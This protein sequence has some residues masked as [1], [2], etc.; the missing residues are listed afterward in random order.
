MDCRLVHKSINSWCINFWTHK[1]IT[2]YVGSNKLIQPGRV[3]SNRILVKLVLLYRARIFEVS[4]LNAEF[5]ELSSQKAFNLL[6]WQ[7]V[8]GP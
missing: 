8:R 3:H 6:R 5:S 7:L 2:L 1:S 4:S